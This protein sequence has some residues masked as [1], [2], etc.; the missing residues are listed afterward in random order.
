MSTKVIALTDPALNFNG[1]D[2][3]LSGYSEGLQL[4]YCT[5]F[6]MS[7][8]TFPR[9]GAQKQ[10]V[11]QIKGPNPAR[12][13]FHVNL[14]LDTQNRFLFELCAHNVKCAGVFSEPVSLDAWHDVEASS[15]GHG[16]L[17]LK[18]DGAPFS[19]TISLSPTRDATGDFT[20]AKHA[21]SDNRY[22]DGEVQD[23]QMST[24]R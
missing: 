10:F 15:D 22:Y 24:S 9:R 12:G 8:R 19:N 2:E 23:F 14:T 5:P 7:L 21:V 4:P 3:Y 1:T 16:N 17:V 11:V 13:E 20:I 6:T 18:V